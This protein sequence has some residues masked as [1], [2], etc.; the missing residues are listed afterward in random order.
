MN[1]PKIMVYQNANAPAHL[2]FLACFYINT[3]DSSIPSRYHTEAFPCNFHGETAK[4]AETKL[5]DW[6]NN[7]QSHSSAPVKSSVADVGSEIKVSGPGRGKVFMGKKWVVHKT[8]GGKRV[9]ENEI[10]SYVAMGYK[11]GKKW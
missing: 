6:W 11:I 5:T 3:H 8:H 1:M 10:D 9:D 2:Q 4:D 7:I